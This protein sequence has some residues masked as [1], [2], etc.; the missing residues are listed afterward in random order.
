MRAQQCASSRSDFCE[1]NTCSS[2]GSDQ[3]SCADYG[4]DGEPE[5][6]ELPAIACDVC[7]ADCFAQ[8][9]LFEGSQDICPKCFKA[10]KK[11]AGAEKQEGGEAV[12][13]LLPVRKKQ[14]K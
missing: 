6:D 7:S 10:D 4:E 3:S 8:S 13:A 11:Y 2:V 1:H 9:Y 12:P 5:S 14:K